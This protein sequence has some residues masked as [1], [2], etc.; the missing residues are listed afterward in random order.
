MLLSEH[1]VLWVDLSSITVFIRTRIGASQECN[2]KQRYVYI[3]SS[4]G[5]DDPFI[6]RVTFCNR[7]DDGMVFDHPCPW[8]ISL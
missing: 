8:F 4:V 1:I 7:G 6:E 5:P 3:R 2:R